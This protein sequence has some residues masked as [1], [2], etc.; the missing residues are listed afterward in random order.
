VAMAISMKVVLLLVVLAVVQAVQAA[1][2]TVKW[3]F[4]SKKS[5][6]K[7]TQLRTYYVGDTLVFNYP[8]GTHDVV[9][10]ETFKEF[11]ECTMTKPIMPEYGN[12]QTKITLDK[13]GPHYF[14]CSIPGH[15][16][17]GMKIKVL[18]KHHHGKP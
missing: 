2:Y 12:G 13:P 5:F 7:S 18:V 10:V 15:C 11:D 14:I 3:Q 6:F 16:T 17:D 8:E 4:P 1:E 9:K